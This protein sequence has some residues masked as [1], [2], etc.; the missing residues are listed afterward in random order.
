MRP[1][2]YKLN[3]DHTVTPCTVDEY[4]SMREAWEPEHRRVGY[5][6]VGWCWVSTVFLMVDH[7]HGLGGPPVLFETMIFNGPFDQWQDRYCTWDEAVAGH[8]RAV[9]KAW[10]GLLLYPVL[11]PAQLVEEVR[12]RLS[13]TNKRS[14]PTRA[15]AWL[16]R[17]HVWLQAELRAKRCIVWWRCYWCDGKATRWQPTP[18]GRVPACDKCAVLGG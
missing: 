9:R 2:Y 4:A 1:L 16:H 18:G 7:S 5:V 14:L 3:P 17:A 12:W 11:K 10:L 13:F 8:R 6:R 15:R